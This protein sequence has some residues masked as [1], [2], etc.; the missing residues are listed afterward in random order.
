MSSSLV[1]GIKRLGFLTG[2]S[3]YRSISAKK[4][5]IFFPELKH[6]V[7]LRKGAT[8]FKVLKQ[9]LIRGEYDIDF[10]FKPRYIID[11]G[12]NIG[13]FAVLFASRFPD[14]I[15]VAVEPETQNY[16]QLQRN[17]A[18]YPNV[19]PVQA[20]IWNK[21]CHLRI[22]TEGLE[23]WGFQVSETTAAPDALPAVSIP[24]IMAT[25]QWPHLDIVKLDVEGAESSI[26]ADNYA[27]LEK[28]KVLIIELHE[29]LLPGSSASFQKAMAA[30]DFSFTQLGENLIYRN[31]RFQ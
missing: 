15:I 19:I 13:L 5:T 2:V 12:A 11:G 26:F 25:Q 4:E 27:W 17:I 3:V 23:D 30:H 8:D 28:T 24:N 9:V 20:G 14:A 16:R 31:N 7:Y 10:P 21:D 1:D 18:G 6:P 22:I 29:P